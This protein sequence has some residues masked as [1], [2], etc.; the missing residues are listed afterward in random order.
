MEHALRTGGDGVTAA[1]GKQIFDLFR[2][3]PDEAENF[4]RAM[5]DFTSHLVTELLDAYDFSGIH[6]LA[7]VGGGHGILLVNVLRRYP[8]LQGVLFD[9][10]EVIAGATEVA[11]FTGLDG[12]IHYEGGSFLETVPEGCDAYIMK[13]IIHDWDDE[14]AGQIL[15]LMKERMAPNGRVLLFEM[16]VPDDTAPGPAKLLDIEMLVNTP[17]GKERTAEEFAALFASAGL[18][19]HRI[20][21]TK[22]PMSVIEAR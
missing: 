15:R 4:H 3:I 9:L 21:P 19:L 16:V 8:H 10:P 5:T 11:H 22:G 1:F 17:G 14:R 2:E 20:V 6:K 13:H 12:R 7:D 18:R